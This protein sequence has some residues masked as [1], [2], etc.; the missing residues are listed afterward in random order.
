M[1][2]VRYVDFESPKAGAESHSH[3]NNTTSIRTQPELVR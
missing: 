3:S 2:S 1:T